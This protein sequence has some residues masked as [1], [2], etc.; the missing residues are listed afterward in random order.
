MTKTNS[1]KRIEERLQL[2]VGLPLTI[3]RN[4]ANMKVLHFGSIRP[5]PSGTGTVG[6]FAI[7]IQCPWRI[8][9]ESFI[10]TGSSDRFAPPYDGAISDENDPK[11]GN[12]QSIKTA[13]LLK[14]YDNVT[15]SFVNATDDL[16]VIAATV[17]EYCGADLSLSGGYRLQIF[18]DG[19]LE[20]D[21]RFIEIEGDHLVIAG[22]QIETQDE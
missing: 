10:V 1:Q 9:A 18:P 22:G 17:D 5:H 11:A 19:S 13:A 15:R 2:L 20:E 16:I 8:V 3:A 6:A 7:H 21:W 12:L 14:C 4:A